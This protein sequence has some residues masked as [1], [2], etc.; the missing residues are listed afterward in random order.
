MQYAKLLCE[1]NRL[2]MAAPQVN[3]AQSREVG[4]GQRVNNCVVGSWIVRVAEEIQRFEVGTLHRQR[5]GAS[6]SVVIGF[7]AEDT[8]Q[9]LAIVVQHLRQEHVEQQLIQLRNPN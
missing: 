4:H 7:G 3:A 2:Q 8:A 9:R 5:H 1:R 6:K